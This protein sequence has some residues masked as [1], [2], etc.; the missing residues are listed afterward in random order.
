VNIKQNGGGARRIPVFMQA[1]AG[2]K[3]GDYE[4]ITAIGK[5]MVEE[6]KKA[7]EQMK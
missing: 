4:S 6:V 7:R 3:T 2:A 1:G 5:Q